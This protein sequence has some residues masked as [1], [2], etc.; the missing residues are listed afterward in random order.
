MLGNRLLTTR[1]ELVGVKWDTDEFIFVHWRSDG[2]VNVNVL[3]IYTHM[4]PHTAGNPV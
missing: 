2:N 3:F 1:G 4:V